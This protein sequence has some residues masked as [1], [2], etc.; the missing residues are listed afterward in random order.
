VPKLPVPSFSSNVYWLAGLL[1]GIGNG[2]RG[3]CSAC[4]EGGGERVSTLGLFVVTLSVLRLLKRE[5]GVMV[6]EKDGA[7]VKS[8]RRREGGQ[9]VSDLME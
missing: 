6:K 5:P 8:A 4:G 9:A 3:I 2:S 1:L 7:K